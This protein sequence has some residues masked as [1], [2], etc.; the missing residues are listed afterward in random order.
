MSKYGQGQFLSKQVNNP[1]PVNTTGAVAINN[2]KEEENPFKPKQYS[3]KLENYEN[4]TNNGRS[5]LH[6][7]DDFFDKMI[8]DSN[9]LYG[10]NYQQ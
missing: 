10:G 4:N 2:N 3:S 9:N 5:Q 8:N 7:K 6:M 1:A